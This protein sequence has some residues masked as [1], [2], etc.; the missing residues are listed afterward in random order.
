[1]TTNELAARLAEQARLSEA[2]A[3]AQLGELAKRIHRLVR[4]GHS[5]ELPGL[6]RF[7]PGARLQ[8][9]FDRKTHGSKADARRAAGKPQD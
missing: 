2:E 1:M 9:R 6:G 5:V 7:E 4:K 8:F 3:A